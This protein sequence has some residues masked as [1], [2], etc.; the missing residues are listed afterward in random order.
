MIRN[1]MRGNQMTKHTKEFA[2]EK[3]YTQKHNCECVEYN[4]DLLVKPN[5]DLNDRFKAY[6]L[7]DNEFIIVNGWML[8][9]V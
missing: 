8:S 9:H 2:L 5:T 6:C 7:S 4:F 3:G 1:L